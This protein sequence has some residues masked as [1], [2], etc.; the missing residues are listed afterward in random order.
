[1][2]CSYCMRYK[3]SPVY[4]WYVKIPIRISCFE[5]SGFLYRVWSQQLL[6]WLLPLCIW[7]VRDTRT[8][9]VYS[10]HAFHENCMHNTKNK[11]VK[12]KKS[13]FCLSLL[14]NFTVFKNSYK[15]KL[16]N[17]NSC[18]EFDMPL[19]QLTCNNDIWV[20]SSNL[21]FSGVTHRKVDKMCF[22]MAL[23]SISPLGCCHFLTNNGC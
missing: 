17:T 21:V 4:S 14:D 2:P 8:R 19:Q 6:A 3:L 15:F 9:V 1:M 11:K 10:L 5:A 18:S 20:W 12:V 22:I 7:G 13:L 23:W 16:S